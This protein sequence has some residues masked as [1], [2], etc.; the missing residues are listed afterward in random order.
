MVTALEIPTKTEK[1]LYLFEI[2]LLITFGEI[3]SIIEDDIHATSGFSK[4]V[5]GS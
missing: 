5:S 4:L 2:I 3:M 1:S